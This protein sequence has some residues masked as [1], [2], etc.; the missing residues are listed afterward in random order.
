MIAE[1]L[2]A[3]TGE[4]ATPYAAYAW[5]CAGEVDLALDEDRARDRFTRAIELAEASRTAFVVGTA[6]ASRAS[7]DAREGDPHA[8]AAQYR[9]LIDHWRRA[10]AWSTQWTM[11]RS[12][13]GL[14]ARLGRDRD[15]AVL[16]GAIHATHAGHRIFGSDEVTLRE[17]GA[18]LERTLGA[19]A[20]EAARVEG[21]R[22]DGDAAVEHALRAL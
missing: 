14:L 12:I 17:L 10:G 8:A 9:R 4:V 16:V 11:L 19:D 21:A 3:I 22:L 18:R 7:I 2:L 20:Y 5:Y 15:A 13:A 6:G 1:E